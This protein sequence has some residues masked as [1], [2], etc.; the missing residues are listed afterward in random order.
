[1]R[2]PIAAVTAVLLCLG[3]TARASTDVAC[4]NRAL[5]RMDFHVNP[6]EGGDN[7]F[8]TAVSGQ[9]GNTNVTLLYPAKASMK[10]FLQRLYRIR[11]GLGG[12][13]PTG[14]TNTYLGGLEYF[15][16][17]DL[18]P[19]AAPS[20]LQ[21]PYSPAKTYPDPGPTYSGGGGQSDGL[22]AG[23][24]YRYG[25]WP[26]NG[27][28][29]AETVDEACGNAGGVTQQAACRT[30]VDTKGYWL[31]PQVADNDVT[32]GAGVFSTNWLRFH[33][34]KWTL[35]SLAYKRLVN[36]PLLSELRDAVV[37]TNGAT[38]AGG[39]VVQK[40]LPQSCNGQGR[41]LN[42]K[43][44]AID[45]LSYVSDANPLAEMLL[46]TAWY[47]G[48]Q[49]DPWHYR[50]DASK[51]G[52]MENGKSGPCDNCG[53][54]FIVLFSDGRGDTANPS[55]TRD[56]T[57]ALPHH[58][59]AEALCGTL[60]MGA[61]DDGDDFLDPSIVGGPGATIS[62][63]A[64]R[65]TPG[66]TCSS[67]FADDVARW[68]R[69]YP[70]SVSPSNGNS[71][72]RTYVVAIG[73]SRNVYGELTT[74]QEVAREGGTGSPIYAE[75]FRS[76]ERGIEDVITRI[77]A[78]ATSFSAAAIPSVQTRGITS[79]FI[80]RFRPGNGGQWSGT[81][82]RF[83]LYNE[84][85]AGCTTRDYGNN[86]GGVNPNR[87]NSCY[88][89]Y[90]RD[91]NGSF[92]GEDSRGD[93]ALLDHTATWDGGWPLRRGSDGGSVPAA[94]IWEAAAELTA[95]ADDIVAGGSSPPRSI[96]TVAPRGS[97]GQYDPTLVPFDLSN[98]STL[99]PLL[100]L[101]GVAGDFC[102]TLSG[103]TRNPYATEEDCA[104]DVIRFVH[105]EDVLRRNPYNRTT[106]PPA[107]LRSRPNVLGDIF[108]STPVLVTPPVPPFLCD[109]GIANQ[110]VASLYMP[111]L[112]PG[113][114]DAYATYMRAHAQ[115]DQ[116]VLV[117]ANDGML[118]A[119]HAGSHVTT[120][121]GGA[122]SF[123]LGTGEELWAFIP[124]DIL[125]KLIRY[126][127]G[128]RHELLVDGTPMVRD[129]WADG[130]GAVSTPDRL[131]QADEF[132]TVAIVGEREGGRHFFALDVTDPAS[133]RF[134]W[135]AP[136]P[137]TS[138]ALNQGESWND[139]GPAAPPIGPIA[140]EDASGAFEVHGQRARERYVVG[141]G[142][143]YD[144]ALL[145]GRSISLLDAWTGEQV[146]RFS[147]ADAASA[148]DPRAQLAPVA[149][150]V[151]LIDSN[152]DGLFDTGVVGDLAGQVWTLDMQA[153]G[154]DG[155]SDG[156]YD[157]WSGG[158]GFVQFKG[159]PFSRRSPFF[160]RA[161]V[162]LLPGGDIRVFIGSGDR[163]NIK[164][165]NGGTCGLA[166]LSSCIRKGCSVSVQSAV[167]RVGPAPSGGTSGHSTT[168]GWS[169]TASALAP[170]ASLT[171]DSLSQGAS[172]SDV[173]DVD[174][175]F[176]ITCGGTTSSFS[177]GLYC[178]W[179]AD[180]GV[181]CPD[182]LGRPLEAEVA[183]TPS[184]PPEY[185]NFF[186]FKLFDS[187][188]RGRSTL[189]SAP[190]T[191]DG[192]AL[193]G[194]DLVDVS[195]TATAA[196]NGN[197]WRL[198]HAFSRD[199][200]TA[201]SALLLGGCVLWNTLEP[202]PSTAVACGATSL[203]ADTAYLYQADA[204]SGAIS[205]G[206]AGSVTYASTVRARRRDTHIAPHQ[207]APLITVNKASGEIVYSGV[208]IEPGSA[209]LSVSVGGG[210]IMGPLHWL[211]VPRRV[212]E[213]RHAAASCD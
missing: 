167:Y 79:A 213:C 19:P 49:E 26:A 200:K 154:D 127:I 129:I 141:L 4:W 186:S 69:T 106:P 91:S 74:L 103:Y 16:P 125:P 113:G 175:D 44:G 161:V 162:A 68:M 70:A 94:P 38:G 63:S 34:P 136:P 86:D 147:A 104:R 181:E 196:A 25:S 111:G 199:E 195:G 143:G 134:L 85:A 65:L 62:G 100:Q 60:G 42:Q 83:D 135:S 88:D 119:F 185:S 80:P 124:P 21:G 202:N 108:H 8:F 117:A 192:A 201:S 163:D 212:H 107:V 87:N 188:S 57:G 132:H 203:P 208:S 171:Y 176:S 98:V 43:R 10:S 81:L 155:D 3:S 48:G 17:S 191:Y 12:S 46:A 146:Y 112:A 36:G 115:R 114:A 11:A 71:R 121:D 75:D 168:G 166:N 5:E 179:G 164:E 7:D 20:S 24:A 211:E 120:A 187:G 56:S 156:R 41:P 31:N 177:S 145:R 64:A 30:C 13:L 150:P 157:N 89:L 9:T 54:D 133:P 116:L 205:C 144:P 122:G 182:A 126:A 140:E 210:D 204:I 148:T 27:G 76:L 93:F 23:R 197:G 39:E 158:R 206:T 37:A 151:S 40:M 189:Q 47:M 190:A 18:T 72:I 102:T 32:P 173:A 29:T 84:F 82:T 170:T 99:T 50:M 169:Y 139:L 58:C 61:E 149:A 6:P 209:P 184:S 159:Q 137:G 109:L 172:C 180:G 142:G 73:D 97:T 14:C 92:V 52:P 178:D 90:L 15:M 165:P 33:P 174:L 123:D 96:Y 45:G 183:Y 28:G 193:T 131:K 78:S 59:S 101:G 22:Q 1:M 105:G 2:L 35:L 194:S 198:T 138:E 152:S 160:Q 67:D 207:P 118:H 66:G 130:S 51:R 128:E 53:G 77:I 55:C 153:P 110:C 95:R